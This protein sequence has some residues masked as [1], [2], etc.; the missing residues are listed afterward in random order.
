MARSIPNAAYDAYFAYFSAC[1]NLVLVS[2][3]TTPTDLTGALATAVIDGT[4]FS[5]GAGD[6]DG[7]RMTVAAQNGVDVTGEGDTNHAV[8]V[9]DPSGSPELRLITT[10]SVRTVSAAA[11]D[12]VN[13]GEFYLQV[14][15]PVAP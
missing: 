11:S 5:V 12:K 3:T 8:L 14:A 1:T 10:C 7:R 13:M 2:D 9:Y 4:D 15:A 6:P